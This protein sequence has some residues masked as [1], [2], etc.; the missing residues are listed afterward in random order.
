MSLGSCDPMAGVDTDV[1]VAEDVWGPEFDRLA[2]MMRVDYQPDL[3]SDRPRLAERVSHSRAIV[4]RNRTQVSAELLAS[5]ALQVIA[6]AGAGLDNIDVAAA[7]RA[8]IVVVAALGANARSV[9]EHTL[10]L[11]FALARNIAVHDSAIRAGHWTR[12]P[13]VELS[14]CTWGVLGAGA[15]GQAVAKLVSASLGG[16]VLGYDAFI[17]PDDARVRDA[18]IEL[19][20]LDRVIEESDVVSIHLPSSSQTRGLAG[21]EFLKKMRTHAFLIN[22]GRGEVVDELALVE[23]LDTG[24]IAAAALDVRASEPPSVGE[25][26]AMDNVVLTP[27][28]AGITRQSQDRVLTMLA[29]DIEALFAGGEGRHVVGALHRVGIVSREGRATS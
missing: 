14:G 18:G 15:T 6:R 28:V 2:S 16:R 22:V 7:N 21:K 19:T 1:L 25:L 20:T 24:Q 3:W 29:T 10:G 5:S 12:T 26:E 4:V 23:A 27:H 17:P 8:G 13:G 11:A 9:A